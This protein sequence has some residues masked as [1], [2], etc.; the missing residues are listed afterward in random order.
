MEIDFT[1]T[2]FTVKDPGNGST[3]RYDHDTQVAADA[4]QAFKRAMEEWP[5][6]VALVV[7][8]HYVQTYCRAADNASWSGVGMVSRERE[9]TILLDLLEREVIGRRFS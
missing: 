7:P 6:L 2:A 5:T 4:R 9:R 1:P 3:R 8:D